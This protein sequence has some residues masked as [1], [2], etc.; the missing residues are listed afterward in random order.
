MQ[1]PKEST[2]VTYFYNHKDPKYITYHKSLVTPPFTTF[3]YA[4]KYSNNF[5]K[6]NKNYI[7]N[8]FP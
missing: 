5:Q 8:L 7:Y 1:K 6:L 3:N 4:S 2:L